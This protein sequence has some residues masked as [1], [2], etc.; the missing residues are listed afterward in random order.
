MAR[1]TARRAAQTRVGGRR[2]EGDVAM[3]RLDPRAD[4]R[5]GMVE[6]EEMTHHT[7]SETV[8]AHAAVDQFHCPLQ[9]VVGRFPGR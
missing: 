1:N 9:K 4:E 5:V 8:V 6:E 3:G 2:V 7:D